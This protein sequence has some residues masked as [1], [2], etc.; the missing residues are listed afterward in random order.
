MAFD[1]DTVRA[2]QVD[3]LVRR[4]VSEVGMSSRLAPSHPSLGAIR[5]RGVMRDTWGEP[6]SLRATWA[7]GRS[8]TNGPG[9]RA[10]HR[11]R[12]QL[13]AVGRR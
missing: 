7:K 6:K 4:A 9:Y 11:L 13:A 5:Y 8:A 3:M 12:Q 2:A 1:P 10:R